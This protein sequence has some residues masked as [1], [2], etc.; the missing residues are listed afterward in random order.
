MLDLRLAVEPT[1]FGDSPI[2]IHC[3][4]PAHD[5]VNASM[6]VYSEHLHCF[7]CGFHRNDWD[8]A[9]ALLLGIT[10][11]EAREVAGQYEDT[12]RTVARRTTSSEGLSPLP[13][14]RAELYHRYML[15]R[16]PSKAGWF[17]SRGLTDDTIRE[18]RLGYDGFRYT[19]PVYGED[20]TLRTIRY[21]ADYTRLP[22]RVAR[23]Y[24][25]EEGILWKPIPK[26]CGITGRNGLYLYGAHWIPHDT[27][28]VILCEGELDALLLHQLGYVAISAT[29]G[30]NQARRLPLLVQTLAPSVTTIYI[31]TDTD[32]GDGEKTQKGEEAAIQVAQ[33]C[34]EL[35]LRAI[36]LGWLIGKD[37]TEMWNR[38]GRLDFIK[39]VWDGKRFIF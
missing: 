31:A 19:I 14:G 9:L 29:N 20:R 24:S 6:A 12:R 25:D 33:N 34:S 26:Y 8:E 3:L 39:G 36:R 11:V 17:R 10:V 15:V 1:A 18:A 4:N 22:E 23:G 13:A 21:R 30:A 2:K 7:G 32:R 16:H 28:Y 5:D 35:G 27:K 37:V 38:L